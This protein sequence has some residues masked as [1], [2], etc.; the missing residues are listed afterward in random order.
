MRARFPVFRFILSLLLLAGCAT[1]PPSRAPH[2]SFLAAHRVQIG[3]AGYF[4]AGAAAKELQGQEQWDTEAQVWRFAVGQHELRAAA[5]MPVVL[6]DGAA[7]SL[8]SPPLIREGLL[9][10]PEQLWTDMLAHWRP[11][12]YRA[13]PPAGR[14]L[15]M[16]AIDAGH[17]GHDPGAEGRSG[18][19]EKNVTLDIARRLRDLLTQDG[20]QVVMTRYDDRF[21]PLYGRTAIA[22]REGVDLFV[23]VHANA[24]RRRSVSGFEAYYLSEATDDHARAI[25]AAENAS[26][27]QEVD[28]GV[29]RETEAILWDLLYTENRAES[30]DLA[31]HICRGLAGSGLLSSNRGVKSARFAVLKGSRMPAVLVEV[32][33]I[34]HP[35]EEARLRE[36]S[37][38]QRVAEGIRRGIASFRDEMERSRY[39]DAR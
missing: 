32:G 4:P 18:L 3:S 25:E 15:R 2:A 5:R 21:V 7:F 16:I 9:Y 19:K 12:A 28:S 33:F 34:S 17:G 10:L 31:V 27:P 8:R 23:S 22:N 36:A 6:A 14:A 26:L 39:A 11:P 29:T 1:V 37:Y 13:A 20:F 24:S 30:S 35:S 38:R